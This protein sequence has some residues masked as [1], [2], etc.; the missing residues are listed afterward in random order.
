MLAPAPTATSVAVVGL[1]LAALAG[2]G[3]ISDDPGAAWSAPAATG[4]SP[5]AAASTTASQAAPSSSPSPPPSP[6]P[7]A[8]S[9]PYVF[10]VTG[11]ASY[12]R[13]HHDYPAA[14]I[15]AA[16]G[17]PVQAVTSGVILEVTLVDRYDARQPVN[18]D[19]GGLSWSMLGDDGVRYYGSHLS[20]IAAGI[21]AGARVS[22]GTRLGLVGRTGNAGACHLHFGISPPC[23]R[24]GDWWTRRGTIWPWP[25]L[26]AWRSGQSKSP[27]AEVT[28]W[29]GS[30]GCPATAPPV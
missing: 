21:A 25:Y 5:S 26:D 19:K 11:N 3:P 1:A 17:L 12:A 20:T 8:T 2:C 4:S 27:A 18:A 9:G 7:R 23:Q 28:T 22:A 13:T 15:I 6:S 30:N 16:C 10:P 14:D 24:T 29:Q